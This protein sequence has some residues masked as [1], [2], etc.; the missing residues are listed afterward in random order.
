MF[1]RLLALSFALAASCAVAQVDSN[2]LSDAERTQKLERARVLK[3]E[4]S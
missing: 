4:A 2:P 1:F 3:E